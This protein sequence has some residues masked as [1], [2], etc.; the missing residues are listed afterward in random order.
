MLAGASQAGE[1]GARLDVASSA[2]RTSLIGVLAA[3]W[4]WRLEL[5]RLALVLAARAAA[6]ACVGELAAAAVVAPGRRWSWRPGRRGGWRGALRRRGCGGR[7]RA[8]RPTS[9]LAAGPFRVPARARSSSGSPAGDVLRVRVLRGQSVL[10]LDARREELAACLRVREVRVRAR[11]RGRRR[12]ARDAGAARSVR[13]RR[14]APVAGGR[15]AERC[16]CGSRSRSA[17]TSTA[18][19]CRIGLVERNVLVGGEPGAGKSVALSLLVA[20]AALD[21]TRGCGCWTASSSSWRRGRRS[22]SGSSAR[23]S[24]RRS[25]LLR[26]AA[27]RDG[28][29]LSRAARARAAQGPPRGRAAAAPG[30]R[31]RARVLPVALPDTQAAPGVRRAA[32]RPRRAWPRGRR[33]RRARRR[34]SPAPTSC[35]RRCATCSGSGSRCAATRRRRRTRSSARAGRRPAATRRRCRAGSAASGCCSPRSE[36][37]DADQDLPPRPTTSSPRSPSAPAPG[38]R[39]HGWPAGE[40]RSGRR[41]ADAHARAERCA[42]AGRR[43]A[44][45]PRELLAAVGRVAAVAGGRRCVLLRGVERRARTDASRPATR[46]RVAAC[47]GRRGRMTRRARSRSSS[48]PRT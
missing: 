19:S 47:G 17:S 32:A 27:A 9:G 38:G 46:P 22:R 3:A 4:W 26:D 29:A 15:G 33:D 40:R 25:T 44:R 2:G 30:R 18:S 37:P 36:R 45:T 31:R 21:P 41:W 1:P 5:A 8:R 13:G 35:R 12:R 43:R 6:R 16:R 34:R 48:P 23:T 42:R 10:A 11:A 24:T 14:A 39:T 20:A 28:G 7:G